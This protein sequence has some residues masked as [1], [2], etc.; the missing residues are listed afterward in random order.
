MTQYYYNVDVEVDNFVGCGIY[1]ETVTRSIPILEK[2]I[3]NGKELTIRDNF[4]EDYFEENKINLV[5]KQITEYNKT[6][7][8]KASRIIGIRR[9]VIIED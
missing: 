8:A 7:N 4:T 3:K 9:T 5:S 2:I 1:N 6:H